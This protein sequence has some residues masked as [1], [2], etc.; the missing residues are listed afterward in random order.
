M[1]NEQLSDF[2]LDLA[3]AAANHEKREDAEY[4]KKFLNMSATNTLYAANYIA[5]NYTDVDLIQSIVGQI[6]ALYYK[7]GVLR[8]YA[9]QFIPC[10]VSLYMLALSKKQQKSASLFET[11]FIALYNEEIVEPNSEMKKVEEIR[12]PSIRQ[13]SIYHDPSKIQTHP[14][15]TLIRPNNLS[16]LV[17]TVRIGPYPT[18]AKF[19]GE[20]KF[21]ILT[22]IMKS[23][24]QSLFLVSSEVAS[25]HMCLAALSICRSGFSFPETG[26]RNKVLDSE[27]SQEVIED[28]SKKPRQHI[29][30]CLL[31][32][33]LSGCY[34]ALFNGNADLA[35]R[36]I[37]SIHLRAQYEILPD[38]LLVVNSVRNSL[39][40]N[41]LSK[42]KRDELM[43][44]RPQQKTLTNRKELV[45]NASL[46]MRRMP[47]DIPVQEES[48]E[49]EHSRFGEL[50]EEGMDHLHDLKSKMKSVGHGIQ[51]KIQRRRKSVEH[52]ESE[53]QTIKEE[54]T[55]TVDTNSDSAMSSPSQ[56]KLVLNG[57][58]IE[59]RL[60]DVQITEL[61]YSKDLKEKLS[62][63][64]FSIGGLRHMDSGS[65]THR[66][67]DY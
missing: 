32:E 4:C 26:F 8:L 56:H 23:V 53:L 7:G 62:F 19:T 25:R 51:H 48:R 3:K 45:T 11:F 37:D 61:D 36:A 50:V 52:E 29:A 33:L 58:E 49:K 30:G 13:P 60:R 5:S 1:N 43:W 40:D 63:G 15:I 35:L 57:D 65:S 66:S 22:R 20:N 47:E 9:L 2:L 55:T 28:Y 12:I 42:E 31:L 44:T 59:R 64:A 18:I 14:E 24:N 27:M 46:R 39:L 10:F 41:P 34:L 38:V 21:I 16:S 67:I 17:T 6:L 54:K